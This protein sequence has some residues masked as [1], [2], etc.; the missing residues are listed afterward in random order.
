MVEVKRSEFEKVVVGCEGTHTRIYFDFSVSELNKP[1]LK[2]NVVIALS[3]AYFSLTPACNFYIFLLFI[4]IIS[5]FCLKYVFTQKDNVGCYTNP[6]TFYLAL[7]IV[8][9]KV[10]KILVQ[11]VQLVI[12]FPVLDYWEIFPKINQ[13]SL[14]SL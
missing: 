9:I 1:W 4:I 6:I 5:P 14:L 11:S 12:N 2:V 3:H 10:Y 7:Y 13:S 8:E